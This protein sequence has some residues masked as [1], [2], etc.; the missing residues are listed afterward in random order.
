M[1][2]EA[3]KLE[4]SWTG[5][6][7]QAELSFRS[8]RRSSSRSCNDKG[9]VSHSFPLRSGSRISVPPVRRFGAFTLI[10][11]LV[12]IAIIAILAGLL[13]P[14]LAIVKTR[15]KVASARTE[16]RNLEAAIKGYEAEYHRFPAGSDVESAG[17]ANDFT[18]G[19]FKLSY[20]L[21]GTPAPPN[22]PQGV[23]NSELVQILMD[24]DGGPST[25]NQDHRRNP[26]HHVLLNPKT[27]PGN[28]PGVSTTDGV[29]SDP[30]GNPYIITM[31]LS[32]DDQCYD[33][34]YGKLPGGDTIGLLQ[35]PAANT[36]V[37][38]GPI[39]IWS[40]GP[41]GQ[42]SP[43]VAAKQGVNK[44]NVLSWQ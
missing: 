19:T 9:F 7:W 15:A 26:R 21:I 20:P 11:L 38:K 18:Y 36:W 12:V 16:M 34:F 23:N 10:E 22:Y 6:E 17:T 33:D 14:A 24:I 31:D 39:M 44:D 1:K 28:N 30:W 2:T 5:S 37:L 35:G 8:R 25:A 4:V 32:G 29:N 27:V 43:T 41:D 40:F 42:F 3:T 13:L